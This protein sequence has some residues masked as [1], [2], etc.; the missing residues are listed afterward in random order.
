VTRHSRRWRRPTGRAELAVRLALAATLGAAV[1]VTLA[2][3]G[4]GG[5]AKGA[6]DVQNGRTLFQ[7]KCAGCHTLSAAGA[8]GTIGPNLDDSFAQARQ[9]GFKESAIREIVHEQILYPGQYS[10]KAGSGDFL[11]ANMPAKLVTGKDAVD[12][13]T[14]VAQN[15]GLQGYT[16]SVVV[17]G[18]NGKAIFV[19]KCAGCHTLKDAGATGTTGP[20][21]DLLKPPFAIA[22]RQV[23]NGGAVMPAFKGTLSDAQIQAVARYVATHAG[24]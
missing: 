6:A 1:A 12:V 21:L 15:A 18:T 10:T 8:Q 23:T 14:F 22:K 24:K 9:E 2:A 4:T 5:L 11:A 13:A 19:S 16:Q 17:T 20:N 7:N 3:C